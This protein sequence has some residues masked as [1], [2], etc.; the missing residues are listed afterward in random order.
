MHHHSL[1]TLWVHTHRHLLTY[2]KSTPF[3]VSSLVQIFDW[4][5]YSGLLCQRHLGSYPVRRHLC[6]FHRLILNIWVACFQAWSGLNSYH[7]WDY[8]DLKGTG[9]WISYFERLHSNSR[10]HYTGCW[11]LRCWYYHNTIENRDS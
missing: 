10:S 7:Y 8:S 4:S 9:A 1:R 3:G 5:F 2:S 11:S 6:W